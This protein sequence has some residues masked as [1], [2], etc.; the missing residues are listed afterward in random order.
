MPTNW[1]Y[2]FANLDR[3]SR[4]ALVLGVVVLI[5]FLYPSNT[6]FKYEFQ[7]GQIWKYENLVAPLDFA[8][9]KPEQEIREDKARVEREFSPFYRLNA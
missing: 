7:K 2:A 1:K 8:I 4:Y 3:L 5:S 6:K 9:K